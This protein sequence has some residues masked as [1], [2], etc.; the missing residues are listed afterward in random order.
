MFTATE[1]K[2]TS[3]GLVRC[4]VFLVTLQRAPLKHWVYP[5]A[6]DVETTL[7]CIIFSLSLFILWALSTMFTFF[8]LSLSL[9]VCLSVCLS[10]QNKD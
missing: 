5:Q 3:H 2:A 10:V 9:S 6:R 1:R 8:T 7:I 4:L